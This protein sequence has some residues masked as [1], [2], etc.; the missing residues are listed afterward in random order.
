[1]TYMA[2][3]DIKPVISSSGSVPPVKRSIEVEGQDIFVQGGAKR[4]IT[5]LSCK[6]C[7]V[8]RNRFPRRSAAPWS[9]HAFMLAEASLEIVSSGLSNKEAHTS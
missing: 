3:V 7:G 8:S 2:C 4:S 9:H 1:M 6:S 5:G